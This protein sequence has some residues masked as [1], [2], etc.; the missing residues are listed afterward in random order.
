LLKGIQK[1][2]AGIPRIEVKFSLNQSDILEIEARDTNTK[3]G[4]NLFTYDR[5]LTLFFFNK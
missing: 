3:N 2:K 1:A 4:L 5:F